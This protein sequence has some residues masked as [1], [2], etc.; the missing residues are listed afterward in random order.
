MNMS[1]KARKAK[2]VDSESESVDERNQMALQILEHLTY[3]RVLSK[4]KETMFPQ[5]LS[6]NTI[7]TIKDAPVCSTL[8]T[9]ISV[10]IIYSN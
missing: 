2:R 5:D 6:N 4:L 9:V 8:W 10:T 7:I 3:G 1:P